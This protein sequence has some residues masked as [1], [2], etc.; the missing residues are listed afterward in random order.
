[1]KFIIFSFILFYIFYN[2]IKM[3]CSYMFLKLLNFS[4][5]ILHP[6]FL[7]KHDRKTKN[8]LYYSS[9]ESSSTNKPSMQDP[10][11]IRC[12]GVSGLIP[13][14]QCRICL[15]LYHHECVGYD[16]NNPEPYVCKVHFQFMGKFQ[17]FQF[18]IHLSELSFGRS[19]YSGYQRCANRFSN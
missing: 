13:T 8:K 9:T 12:S 7:T 6:F 14:L 16:S 1:M 4:I 11:S 17:I 10:C 2:V 5:F 19:N 18:F 15:C 3:S